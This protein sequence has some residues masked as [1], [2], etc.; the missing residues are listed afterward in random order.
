MEAN[1]IRNKQVTPDL[2]GFIDSDPD[3]DRQSFLPNILEAA[4]GVD[5]LYELPY[6]LWLNVAVGD[7]KR[8]GVVV[9]GYFIKAPRAD[10]SRNICVPPDTVLIY[11]LSTDQQPVKADAT[12]QATFFLVAG[13]LLCP[14]NEA[15][16]TDF[17]AIMLF[18]HID[19]E[20]DAFV[21]IIVFIF[22]IKRNRNAGQLIVNHFRHALIQAV[23]VCIAT[24]FSQDDDEFRIEF[25]DKQFSVVYQLFCKQIPLAIIRTGVFT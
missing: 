14:I 19:C 2:Y 25:F 18:L 16:I 17:N 13:H 23:A 11:S 7:A 9:T 15:A 4:S 10:E 24:S 22:G 1:E 5:S 21:I 20:V 3:I 12:D 8:L 6:R